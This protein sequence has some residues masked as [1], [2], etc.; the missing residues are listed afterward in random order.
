MSIIN[1]AV[2]SIWL[3]GLFLLV[4][5]YQWRQRFTGCPAPVQRLAHISLI[6]LGL[7]LSIMMIA[8]LYP[9]G[10]ERVID[11]L[12][13]AR[14]EGRILRWQLLSNVAG[15]F[16]ALAGLAFYALAT[17]KQRSRASA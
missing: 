7:S 2:I 1:V 12:E 11:P 5:L 9:Y 4:R 14:L 10:F 16:V 13:S 8:S 17:I 15:S 3:G 6:M